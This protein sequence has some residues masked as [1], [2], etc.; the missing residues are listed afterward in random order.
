MLI[1][2]LD[3]TSSYVRMSKVHFYSFPAQRGFKEGDTSPSW[4]FKLGVEYSIRK[5][6]ES[7]EIMELN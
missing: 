1:E 7:H 3:E 5:V 4:L 2:R 6:E